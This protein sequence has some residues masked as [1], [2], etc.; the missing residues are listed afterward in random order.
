[1]E[2]ATKSSFFTFGKKKSSPRAKTRTTGKKRKRR[3]K[4]DSF[5]TQTFR[6]AAKDKTLEQIIQEQRD[7]I[8][9]TTT[10]EQRAE[11]RR[12]RAEVAVLK[13]KSRKHLSSIAQ[14]RPRL[15]KL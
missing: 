8:S 13:L 1:M 6:G 11:L 4:D 3:P 5:S 7:V 9:R 15:L 12:V 2:E 10:T 14:N